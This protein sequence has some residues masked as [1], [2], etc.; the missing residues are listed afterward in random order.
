MGV[1]DMAAFTTAGTAGTAC[2]SLNGVRGMVVN[3]GVDDA[4]A[5]AIA[6]LRRGEGGTIAEGIT[7]VGDFAGAEAL[8][9]K[10]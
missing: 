1:L 10:I 4:E 9:Q 5:E 8:L 7:T 2:C 6:V 3:S